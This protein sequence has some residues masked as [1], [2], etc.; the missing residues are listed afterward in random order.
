[1]AIKYTSNSRPIVH[2]HI[3]LKPHHKKLI[4][5]GS[6]LVFIFMITTS[7]FLYMMFVKQ[8]L[9]YNSLNNKI[10]DSRK[11]TQTAINSLANEIIQSEEEIESLSSNL[12]IINEE[13][14][15]LK[16]SV[17]AD[18]SG[19]IDQAVKSVVTIRTDVSQGT[20]FIINEEGFIVTNAHVLEGA[21]SVIA[22]NYEQ[23]TISAE[24][25]GYHS[26]LDIAL[27][28][29]PG[30]YNVLELENSNNVQVGEEVI[31]IGNG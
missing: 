7:I 25:I 18:F 26:D 16:A 11:E 12:G 24:F 17:G 29:I 10:T 30:K 6:S 31:A 22:I 14:G 8:E 5:G 27:L 3:I 21:S 9:N 19:I 28:K 1:M 4:I 23:D 2:H 13:F 15:L 20:G